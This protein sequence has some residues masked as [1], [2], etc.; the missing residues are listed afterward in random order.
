MST[1]FE[2]TVPPDGT[3]PIVL[4]EEFRGKAVEI[5]VKSK[6]ISDDKDFWRKKSLDEIVAEQGG[7][8]VCT[9]PDKL[10]GCLAFLWESPE[11]VED[12]LQ[13]RKEDI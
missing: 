9:D 4:P 1:Q 12:F 13:R 6:P 3:I 10:F 5:N 8:K 7:P 11:D 2:F